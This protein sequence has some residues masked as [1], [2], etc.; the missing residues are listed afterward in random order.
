MTIFA[1]SVQEPDLFWKSVAS[2]RSTIIL[3]PSG[4]MLKLLYD[5][6]SQPH[7]IF[8]SFLEF[9]FILYNPYTNVE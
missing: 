5:L 8:V 7:F 1:S 3:L 4:E 2:T 6:V 9:L